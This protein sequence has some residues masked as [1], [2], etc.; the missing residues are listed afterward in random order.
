MTVLIPL[1]VFVVGSTVAAVLA[2]RVIPDTARVAE[3]RLHQLTSR[4]ARDS[5]PGPG[6]ALGWAFGRVGQHVARSPKAMGAVRLRLARAGFRR[7]EAV[8]IFLGIKMTLA[9]AMAIVALSLSPLLG[10]STIFVA[11]SLVGLGYTL[12]G[13]ALSRRTR[14]RQAQIRAGL[15]D[16]LDLLV[17]SME[18]GL[19]LDQA[20][21]RVADELRRTSPQL[22]E[23]LRLLNLELR[24]ATQR[25]DALRNVAHRTG[26]DDLSA[27]AAMLVQAEQLGVSLAASL[28][29]FSD[30]LRTR[31]R[32]RAE[33]A[34]AKTSVKM[35]FPL[36]LCIFPTIW[37]VTIGPAAISFIEILFP[38]VEQGAR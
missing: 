9:L 33:E 23:E 11:V 13:V 16:M 4:G 20:L 29:V 6:R 15:P 37:V 26:V 32:Q 25:G 14:R 1:L 31:R 3:R 7:E 22:A 35:L 12:P 38:V 36:A 19:G 30:T 27:L 10:S 34:A 5:A 28:R 8:P 21:R 17:V 18:A 2:L 24:A